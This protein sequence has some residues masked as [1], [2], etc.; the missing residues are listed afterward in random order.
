MAGMEVLIILLLTLANGLFA[1]SEIAVI[2]AR[3]SRLAA[4]AERGHRAAQQAL[5]LANNPERLLAAVQVGITLIGTFAAAFGGA[6]L[7][8][9]LAA[10]LRAIDW[11][12]PY[13]DSVALSI[14]VVLL[15]Y[16]NL[17]LGELAPKRLALQNAEAVAL[18]AAPLLAG[19][20]RIGQPI[21]ALLAGS[22]SLV[23]RLLGQQPTAQPPV[24]EEDITYLVRLGAASGTVAANE[25]QVIRQ[26]FRMTD[27]PLRAVMTPRTEITAVAVTDSWERMLQTFVQSA[28]SRLPVYEGTLD[29]IVGIVHAKD[30]LS[31]LAAG[32]GPPADIKALL[33][34]AT[35]VF[36]AQHVGEVLTMLQRQRAHLAIVLDEYGQVAGLVTL[37]DL[38]EELVG[39]IEDEYDQPEEAPFVQ[40]EDGSWLIDGLEAYDRVQEKLGLPPQPEEERADYTTLAGWVVARLGRMPQVG[41]TITTEQHIV[42]VVDMD[43]RRIDKVLIRPR[44]PTPPPPNGDPEAGVPPPHEQLD[45]G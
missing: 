31:I 19:I 4:L 26:A 34:P 12:A 23:L 36:E 28:Y 42:E 45:G 21:V 14:V 6:R 8:D 29:N 37:E 44:Q 30:V 41:D 18:A 35:F 24:T 40:R 27:R 17:V 1:A 16:L 38:L 20:A 10:Q 9:V 25:A 39:E 2:S 33:H 43:G 11:I 32:A 5:T 15:T 13:A 22:A 7:G 3:R